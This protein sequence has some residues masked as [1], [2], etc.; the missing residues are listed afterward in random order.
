M[1]RA[2]GPNRNLLMDGLRRSMATLDVGDES[3]DR[4]AALGTLWQRCRAIPSACEP[5]D[6]ASDDRDSGHR[7]AGFHQRLDVPAQSVEPA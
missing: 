4:C 6:K 2:T 3:A 1:I 5:P 7:R